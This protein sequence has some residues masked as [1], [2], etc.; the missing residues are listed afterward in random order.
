MSA[1]GIDTVAMLDNNSYAH[2]FGKPIFSHDGREW[3]ELMAFPANMVKTPGQVLSFDSA[4]NIAPLSIRSVS[5]GAVSGTD[6]NLIMSDATQITIDVS[7]LVDDTF[8]SGGTFAN[9]NLELTRTDN[10]GGSNTVSISAPQYFEAVSTASLADDTTLTLTKFDNNTVDLALA[11]LLDDITLEATTGAPGTGVFRVKDSGISQFKI[12]TGAVTTI[13]LA[14][15]AVTND[16]IKAGDVAN[17]RLANSTV[18]LTS[19]NAAAS[20]SDAAPA[21]GGSSEINIK[22]DGTTIEVDATKGLQIPSAFRTIGISSQNTA[23]TSTQS[24]ITLG[25][26]TTLALVAD[27]SDFQFGDASTGLQIK[28]SGVS[29]AQLQNNTVGLTTAHINSS[30]ATTTVGATAIEFSHAAP[31]LGATSQLSIKVDGTTVDVGANGLQIAAAAGQIGVT[32]ANAAIVSGTTAVPLGGSTELTFKADTA[33]F[34]IDGTAGLQIKPAGVA[35]AQLLNKAIG[36]TSNDQAA[37]WSDAAPELGGSTKLT[38]NTDG[39]TITT[40]ASGLALVNN[41][42]TI[43]T[44]DGLSSTT[45]APTLGGDTTLSIN[46]DATLEVHATDGLRIKDTAVAAGT[47]PPQ[48]TPAAPADGGD[49]NATQAIQLTVNAK[50]Q[51]TSISTRDLSQL[52]DSHDAGASPSKTAL[53]RC[54]RDHS[55]A[56]ADPHVDILAGATEYKFGKDNFDAASKPIKSLAD[57]IDDQD[58]VT[59]KYLYDRINGLAWMPPAQ[60]ASTSQIDITAALPS[61]FDGV[62]LSTLSSPFRILL[63]NQDDKYESGVYEYTLASNSYARPADYTTGQDVSNKTILVEGGSLAGNIFTQTTT[64]VVVGSGTANNTNWIQITGGITPTMIGATTTP[65]AG[66]SGIVPQPPSGSHYSALLGDATFGHTEKI[67]MQPSSSSEVKFGTTTTGLSYQAPATGDVALKRSGTLTS[68]VTLTEVKDVSAVKVPL[69][70]MP[71]C[72]AVTQ[73]STTSHAGL[74]SAHNLAGLFMGVHLTSK[75]YLTLT[76]DKSISDANSS[77]VDFKH[78]DDTQYRARFQYL[79][80]AQFATTD[81]SHIPEGLTFIGTAETAGA[82]N[83]GLSVTAA[84]EAFA[85]NLTAFNSLY[86]SHPSGSGQIDI[87]SPAKM[88]KDVYAASIK[89]GTTN[90]VLGASGDLSFTRG[91]ALRLTMGS[92]GSTFASTG[93]VTVASATEATDSTAALHVHGG[94]RVEKKITQDPITIGDNDT[95]TTKS[96]QIAIGKG[97]SLLSGSNDIVIGTEAKC[98][99]TVSFFSGYNVVIGSSA[100]STGRDCVVIGTNSQAIDFAYYSV[101]IGKDAKA[102]ERGC[103]IGGKNTFHEGD[104][105]LGW[106]DDYSAKTPINNNT[107]TYASVAIGFS[108][109]AQDNS[110]AIGDKSS[111]DGGGCIVIGSHVNLTQGTSTL[112]I[113]GSMTSNAAAN[114]SGR[115]F[116]DSFNGWGHYD[117]VTNLLTWDPSNGDDPADFGDHTI[118]IDMSDT[119]S[120]YSNLSGKTNNVFV[121]GN[122][123]ITDLDKSILIGHNITANAKTTSIVLN[124]SDSNITIGDSVDDNTDNGRC[125]IAPIR[126]R[127]VDETDVNI[128]YDSTNKELV[129]V[130]GQFLSPT[131]SRLGISSEFTLREVQNNN[132]AP[133]AGFVG[134]NPGFTQNGT[135]GWF[136]SMATFNPLIPGVEFGNYTTTLQVDDELEMIYNDMMGQHTVAT[137]FVATVPNNDSFNVKDANGVVLDDTALQALG[138]LQYQM[139]YEFEPKVTRTGTPD[140]SAPTRNILY[141]RWDYSTKEFGWDDMLLLYGATSGNLTLQAADTTSSYA[142]QFPA[143]GGSSRKRLEIST[144]STGTM[145][146]CQ[147]EWTD[148]VYLPNN[149][150][151]EAHASGT[152]EVGKWYEIVDVGTT[153]FFTEQGAAGN[154][155][156]I[157]FQA[158]VAGTGTGTARNLPMIVSLVSGHGVGTPN[159]DSYHIGFPIDVSNVQVGQVLKISGITSAGGYMGKKVDLEFADAS[160]GSSLIADGSTVI[161]TSGTLS[162]RGLVHGN[163]QVTV[164]NGAEIDVKSSTFNLKTL[165][166]SDYIYINQTQSTPM[167]NLTIGMAD[168][169]WNTGATTAAGGFYSIAMGVKATAGSIGN[170]NNIAIGAMDFSSAGTGNGPRAQNNYCTAIGCNV[171]AGANSHSLAVGWNMHASTGIGLGFN[172][173]QSHSFCTILNADYSVNV[174]TQQAQSLY[175]NPIRER[176]HESTDK[177]LAYDTVNKEVV[178]VAVLPGVSASVGVDHSSGTTNHIAYL[179]H[180]LGNYQSVNTGTLYLTSSNQIVGF[181]GI[182]FNTSIFEWY[183]NDMSMNYTQVTSGGENVKGERFAVKH[184]G[185]YRIHCQLHVQH[186]SQTS[187]SSSDGLPV[188]MYFHR[189]RSNGLSDTTYGIRENSVFNQNDSDRVNQ[190]SYHDMAWLKVG[191]QYWWTVKHST[192]TSHDNDL[193]V[194]SRGSTMYL[195]GPLDQTLSGHGN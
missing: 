123:T 103:V 6:L 162:A 88:W 17:D 106:S 126:Q 85:Y 122:L 46:H 135:T 73:Y 24:S 44:G 1:G 31:A 139:G 2:S 119:G 173:N 96:G 8:V 156:T 125:Y 144:V 124:A 92:T 62:T 149:V 129:S 47:Y 177:I 38:I 7:D 152:F 26:S 140:L 20:W 81:T 108:T 33:D 100:L 50:G 116:P 161:D 30:A 37:T 76:T 193:K 185:F 175:I 57:P 134:F 127:S 72:A 168:T 11:G 35:N 154:F 78:T 48:L 67:V 60:I 56:N 191:E 150:V 142:I 16:K 172:G 36:L 80:Q 131:G 187:T 51:A 98:T 112:L 176:T 66:S 186:V 34:Q 75:P 39:T 153:D 63:A 28:P 23:I 115:P 68:T 4:G 94:V 21:L 128:M 41:A 164:A 52:R 82:V 179:I 105:V 137:V 118:L 59:K 182:K 42:I 19:A 158:I 170:Y 114:E 159:T 54:D 147:L 91:S 5:S 79:N 15:A 190:V 89:N 113:A 18:G 180:Y 192:H 22:A 45:A 195:Y 71:G 65:A 83:W 145:E 55:G 13:K 163:S 102:W 178:A 93:T 95:S 165:T 61:T 70:H 120:N 183:A 166:T 69:L 188:L 117:G 109:H 10:A 29:N 14:P 53:V 40:T 171:T 110:I 189:L 107:T 184:S 43:N 167:S 194:L 74:G 181:S 101:A 90:M 32:S 138:F 25:N 77:F 132:T 49:S 97:A 136:Q 12:A 155:P 27:T 151:E 169:N 121:G 3:I 111:S 87:G 141:P 58:A 64:P 157:Q 146:T 86:P 148:R 130:Q 143:A 84:R 133:Y 160:G 104:V 99:N 174:T 9:G